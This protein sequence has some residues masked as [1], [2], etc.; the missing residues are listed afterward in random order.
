MKIALAQLN[1]CVGDLTGN[2]ARIV[3][4]I[5]RARDVAHAQLVV[6]PEL[7]VTGYPPEDLLFRPGLHQRVEHALR[8]IARATTGIAV[9]VGHPAR[10]DGVVYNSASHIADGAVRAVYRKQRLPN[11]EV[12]DEKR[13]FQA[14]TM[15]CVIDVDGY[16]VGLSICEDIWDP[17]TAIAARGAGAELIVNLNASPYSHHKRAARLRALAAAAG[18]AGLPIAYLNLVGGQDELVFDGGSLAVD[19]AGQV[20]AEAAGFAEELLRARRAAS[21]CAAPAR[22]RW[23]APKAST[24]LSCSACATISRRTVSAAPCSACRAASTRH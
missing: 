17:S 8:E 15:P 20:V 5:V 1:L 21:F 11:Y 22:R 3:E 16:A 2:T 13:Y 23:P 6:F 10:D 12:F 4:T 14:G 19:A 7:A 18:G 24:A 9:V